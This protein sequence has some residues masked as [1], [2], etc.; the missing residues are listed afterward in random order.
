[1]IK[2]VG[3]Y[4]V[5]ETKNLSYIFHNNKVGYLVNDYFGNKI[6]VDEQ[7]IEN[8]GLKE[9]FPKGTATVVDESVDPLFSPDNQLLEYSFAGKGDNKEPALIVKNEKRG[10]VMDFR[11]VKAK[12]NKKIKDITVL[13]MP[14]HLDE[15][16]IITLKDTT[17]NIVLELHY[18]IANDFDVIVRN[19]VLINNEKEVLSLRKISSLQFDMINKNFEVLNLNGAWIGETHPEKQKLH[20][21]IYINDSKSGLSSNYHNSFFLLKEDKATMD[22]GEVY[23]F[24][25]MYSGNHQELVELNAYDHVHIQCG[26]NP[27]FFDYKLNKKQSFITPFALLTY[28]SKGYNLSSQRMADF[29][30]ACV[31]NE[32]F[33]GRLRPVLINNWEA[34]YFNFN[35][36]KLISIA[37]KAKKFGLEL[38]VLDDGWFGRRTNDTKGLGDYDVNKKKLRHGLNGLAKKIN[39]LGLKFGLWMEPEGISV[40]SSIFEQHPEY[41]ITLEGIKPSTGR[42]QLVMNLAKIEVQD[43]IIN[44]VSEVLES[45]NIEYVKWDMNRHITDF[46]GTGQFHHDYVLGLY[47]V[48]ETLTSKFPTVLFENCSS[49]GNRLDLGMMHYFPQTWASDC[50][51]HYERISIQGGLYYGY[52][53][54]CITGHVSSH[55]NHQLLRDTSYADKFP[56]AAFSCLGYELALDELTS[57]QEKV[58]KSQISFYKEHRELLQ[59]GNFYKLKEKQYEGDSAVWMVK[60]KD[61]KEAIIGYFNGLQS[62][63]PKETIIR[64]LGLEEGKKYQLSVFAHEHELKEFGSLVNMVLPFHINPDG[65]LMRIINKFKTI[66]K[67]NDNY[68]LD[69]SILNNGLILKSEWAGNGISENVR[70]LKDFGSRL[71]FIKMIQ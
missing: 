51:D 9:A 36:A 21:G 29:I 48:L 18:Y 33:A 38:F 52:P 16:L 25:L 59:Y 56:V 14:N 10:Y 5:I 53:L 62:A 3:N 67:E 42:H 26:I 30:N 55:L 46:P 23:C 1:M 63:T 40:D 15:E 32:H 11:F 22:Y 4:F 6:K 39:K 50:S 2:Q 66:P 61:N 71:Y 44:R 35:E 20:R 37:K 49:G 64:N 65:M 54:S 60:S 12:I 47:R 34:T 17:L 70:V 57:L 31:I 19:T 24:N 43:Y 69:G 7:S 13:P 41:A 8:L 28:S 45:A 27:T 68:V 58:I